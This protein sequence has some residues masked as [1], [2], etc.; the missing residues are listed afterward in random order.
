MQLPDLIQVDKS[1][2]LWRLESTYSVPVAFGHAPGAAWVVA[3]PS[4]FVS[5]LAS[6]PRFAWWFVAPHEFTGP[7]LVHDL[8][9]RES[10]TYEDRIVA[11]AGYLHLLKEWNVGWFKRYMMFLALRAYAIC[12]LWK[13]DRGEQRIES[14]TV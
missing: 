3:V 13:R 4:G 14:K 1:G 2:E 5:D 7:A 10:R 8:L 12:G 9:C 11:D 6:I